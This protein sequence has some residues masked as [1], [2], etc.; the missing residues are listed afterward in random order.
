VDVGLGVGVLVGLGREVGVAVGF[1][2]GVG[3]GDLVGVGVLVD[4]GVGVKVGVRVTVGV[5]VEVGAIT[6]IV[7]ESHGVASL[8]HH[9]G[10][11]STGSISPKFKIIIST[12]FET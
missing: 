12:S 5:G 2:V 3:V 1:M 6:A 4:T 7:A 11:C 8:V 9:V 10:T